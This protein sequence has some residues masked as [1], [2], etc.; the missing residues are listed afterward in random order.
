MNVFFFFK[1]EKTFHENIDINFTCGIKPAYRNL[2]IKA[3][4]QWRM[5]NVIAF[6]PNV[7][8][9]LIK[10]MKNSHLLTFLLLRMSRNALSLPFTH[11]L[12]VKLS[13]NED[14]FD[15]NVN[16]GMNF[17]QLERKC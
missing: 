16:Q 11:H 9:F 1:H 7:S 5:D 13:L 2:L 15:I 17:K 14:Y 10:F 6:S 3:M 4:Y 12:G 8:L